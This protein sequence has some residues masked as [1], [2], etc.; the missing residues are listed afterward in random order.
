MADTSSSKRKSD[1]LCTAQITRLRFFRVPLVLSLVFLT[2]QAVRASYAQLQWQ[3]AQAE[4]RGSA[5]EKS[6]TSRASD[7]DREV[8][9]D[10]SA[11]SAQETFVDKDR[12]ANGQVEPRSTQHTTQSINAA[13]TTPGVD[14]A[15]TPRS[16]ARLE[17]VDR[18]HQTRDSHNASRTGAHDVQV[19]P[20]V[21]SQADQDVA[22]TQ[23]EPDA[24][25]GVAAS[26]RPQNA[27]S[28][29]SR[30]D[31]LDLLSE[32]MK[33]ALRSFV[34]DVQKT[35]D[36]Q[37]P[38]DQTSRPKSAAPSEV[39]RPADSQ[40]LQADD[41]D[42]R[43]DDSDTRTD[44]ADTRTRDDTPVEALVL[45]NPKENQGG[46]RYLIDGLLHTL[47]P[48]P[49]ADVGFRRPLVNRVPSR[50]RF[51]QRGIC[52]SKAGLRL[53][54]DSRG[55]GSLR[56][57]GFV[58]GIGRSGRLMLAFGPSQKSPGQGHPD[59]VRGLTALAREAEVCS[60]GTIV[61]G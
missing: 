60:A 53:Q 15:S 16:T 7:L 58:G 45:L 5:A 3:T 10:R 12:L 23:I 38:F 21:A 26:E 11:T 52:A 54:T 44:D 51:R 1:P 33:G 46:I 32:S 13:V 29:R 55:L 37:E 57:R 2:M 50:R 41:D 4:S 47:E 59:A 30:D 35:F 56:S 24:A 8:S 39:S 42:A 14:S 36:A 18:S 34:E 20:D 49:V 43:T 40:P 19:V 9:S 6:D 22:T 31:V 28:M 61:M 48:G 27:D 25:A 17:L